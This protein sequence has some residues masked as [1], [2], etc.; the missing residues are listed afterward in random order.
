MY[1][2][3]KAHGILGYFIRSHSALSYT[4]LLLLLWIDGKKDDRK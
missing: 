3:K 4:T 2:K 1:L